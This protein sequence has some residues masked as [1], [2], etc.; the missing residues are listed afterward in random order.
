MINIEQPGELLE[1]GKARKLRGKIASLFTAANPNLG[2][3]LKSMNF[4]GGHPVSLTRALINPAVKYLVCEKTDGVRFLLYI[5][6]IP[7]LSGVVDAWVYLVDRKYEFRK[8]VL[9]VPAALVRDDSL[10]DCELVLDY[11]TEPRLLLFDTIFCQGLCYVYNPYLER[12]QVAWQHFVYPLRMEPTENKNPVKVFLKDFFEVDQI[13]FI[14]GSLKEKLPHECDG[15][16]FTS[17]EAQYEIGSN[18]NILKWK[19]PELNSIDVAVFPTEQQ[20]VFRLFTKGIELDKFAEIRVHDEATVKT[21][22]ESPGTIAEIVGNEDSWKIHRIRSD[23]LH[24]NNSSVT[25]AIVSSIQENVTF[26][27]LVEIFCRKNP[28]KVKKTE[29]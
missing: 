26:E 5:P 22:N 24:P 11:H 15:L 19:P 7:D 28:R 1:E 8:I 13:E 9:K 4:P 10:F 6:G 20:G 29:E 23:K 3:Q 12:L 2:E 17:N 14:W 18:R 16:I 25:R 21:L 27:D